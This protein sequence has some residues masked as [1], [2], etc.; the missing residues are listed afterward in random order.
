MQQQV[1]QMML[2]I[3][4]GM[5]GGQN[6]KE[7]KNQTKEKVEA[8]GKKQA[9]QVI[10]NARTITGTKEGSGTPLDRAFTI[11]QE[12]LGKKDFLKRNADAAKTIAIEIAKSGLDITKRSFKGLTEMLDK[13]DDMSPTPPTPPKTGGDK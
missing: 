3:A 1:N 4:A 8:E 13:E 10:A 6:L 11:A 7:Q 9:D 5:F 12:N 2:Q